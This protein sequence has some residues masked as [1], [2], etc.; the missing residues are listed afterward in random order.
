[1]TKK[2]FFGPQ[3][4]RKSRRAKMD[5]ASR[6]STSFGEL[7]AQVSLPTDDEHHALHHQDQLQEH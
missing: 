5:L 6:V 7:N 2:S 1:M 3:N 4:V